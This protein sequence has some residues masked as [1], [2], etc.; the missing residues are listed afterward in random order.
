MCAWGQGADTVAYF[1]LSQGDKHVMGSSDYQYQLN[2]YTFY[3]SSQENLDTF[4]ADPWTY[5]PQFGSYCSW[6]VSE[7]TSGKWNWNAD[8]LGPAVNLDLWLVHNNKLYLFFEESPYESFQA[9]P[10]TYAAD[11]ETRW[12][13]WFGDLA[14][15]PFNTGCFMTTST[16]DSSTDSSGSGSSAGATTP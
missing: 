3:F 15:G 2:G 1:S 10:T 16:S 9:D 4:S 8:T 12:A 11:G 7:E 6:G 5:A 14:S 13:G